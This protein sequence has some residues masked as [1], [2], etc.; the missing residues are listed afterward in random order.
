MG[1]EK[2]FQHKDEKLNEKISDKIKKPKEPV[3]IKII[4]D[5]WKE[6][7]YK[8]LG[9]TVLLSG[10]V[11]LVVLGV[12]YYYLERKFKGKVFLVVGIS[13]MIIGGL[14]IILSNIFESSYVFYV[15]FLILWGYQ[16]RENVGMCKQWNTN[17]SKGVAP[18]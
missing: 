12:G 9:I 16:L 3:N 15:I 2:D 11:G 1:Y 5:L 4:A 13:L 17:I 10:L 18:W 7:H 14:S 8:K 6:E